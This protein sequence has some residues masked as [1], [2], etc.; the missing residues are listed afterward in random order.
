MRDALPRA[1]AAL[2][3]ALTAAIFLAAWIAPDLFGPQYVANLTLVMLME[4]IVMHSSG[5]YAGLA[6]SNVARAKRLILLCVLTAF[7]ATFIGA[8]AL[9]FDSAWPLLAF[10]WLF[11]SRFA[12]IWTHPV[13]SGTETQRAMMLWVASGAS[14]VIGA[15][16]TVTLPLPRLGM[17]RDFVASM[18]LSGSGE[19]IERPYTV[20][21]FGALYFAVQAWAKYGLAPVASA[22]DEPAAPAGATRRT[23][24]SV[25]ASSF[26][27][28]LG[29]T[30]DRDRRG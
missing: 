4:F 23:L 28:V 22:R 20:L 27:S 12:H 15:I 3:D 24:G 13:E 1:L 25:A 26:S 2:P 6:A 17:T 9:V 10:G 18:H 5:F 29:A 16:V 30:R 7:Y 19:W 14:Y 21:A 8:F 11:L